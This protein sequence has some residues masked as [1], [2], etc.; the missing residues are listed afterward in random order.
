[1]PNQPQKCLGRKKILNIDADEKHYY[2]DIKNIGEKKKMMVGKPLI[3]DGY[4]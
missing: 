2:R 1:M 3:C 4:E